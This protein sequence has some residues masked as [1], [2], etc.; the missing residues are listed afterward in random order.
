MTAYVVL[1]AWS[2]LFGFLALW[3]V[4]RRRSLAGRVVRRKKGGRLQPL[5]VQGRHVDDGQE[6]ARK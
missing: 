2:F 5:Y 4:S 6:T 1:L 3:L